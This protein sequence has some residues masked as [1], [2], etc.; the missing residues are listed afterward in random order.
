MLVNELVKEIK[1]DKQ[2]A[3]LLAAKNETKLIGRSVINA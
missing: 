2:K 3:L 1:V